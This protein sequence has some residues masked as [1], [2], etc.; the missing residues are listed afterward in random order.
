M[1]TTYF[2]SDNDEMLWMEAVRQDEY[3]NDSYGSTEDGY[4]D[5][6]V[7]DDNVSQSTGDNIPE[8]T[9]GKPNFSGMLERQQTVFHL[10]FLILLHLEGIII[11]ETTSLS[12]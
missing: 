10:K 1:I 9:D 6:E 3:V 5:S 2:D 11:Q 7:S 12:L 8:T 4:D